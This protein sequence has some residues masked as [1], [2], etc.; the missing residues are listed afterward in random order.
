MNDKQ[1]MLFLQDEG[2]GFVATSP[3]SN[4]GRNT[5]NKM[6]FICKSIAILQHDHQNSTC[7]SVSKDFVVFKRVQAS[8]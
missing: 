4:M 5:W 2:P 3:V 7:F 8:L 6:R 1:Q